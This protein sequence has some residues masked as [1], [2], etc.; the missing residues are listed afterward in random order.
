[1]KMKKGIASHS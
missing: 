1:M